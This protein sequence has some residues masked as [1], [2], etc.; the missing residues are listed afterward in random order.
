VRQLGNP[1]G[2]VPYAFPRYVP[3]T[4]VDRS[5]DASLNIVGQN[6]TQPVPPGMMPFSAIVPVRVATRPVIGQQPAAVG[7]KPFLGIVPW[8]VIFGKQ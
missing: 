5:I 1:G 7:K 8:Q 4:Y 3:Y 2:K 6:L